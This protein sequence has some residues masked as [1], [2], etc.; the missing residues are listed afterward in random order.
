[1]SDL[2][3]DSVA[4]GKVQKRKRGR[5]LPHVNARNLASEKRKRCEMKEDLLVHT[6]PLMVI[7][8]T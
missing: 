3:N 5:P 2:S 8:S 4:G 1:M 7:L 6:S